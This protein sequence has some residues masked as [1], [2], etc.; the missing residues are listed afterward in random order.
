MYTQ[1][2]GNY[3]LSKGYITN[4]Q[5]FEALQEKSQKHTKLG[6]LAIHSGLM[7]AAEV[8]AV[9]VEQTHQDKK[10]GELTIEMGYLTD[11]QVKNL[12]NIQSPDFLLLG[13]ILLDN[14]IIDNTTLEKIINDYRGENEISDLDMVFEDKESVEHLIGHFFASA[15]VDP[16]DLDKMYLE[17]LFNSF[18]RFVGD[19]F[20]PLSAEPCEEFCADCCVKQNISG[21]YAIS[22]YIGMNQATAINFASRYVKEAFSVYDEYVQASLEDFLNLNNGLFTVNCSNEK[23]LELSLSAPEHFDGEQ[24]TLTNAYKIKVLYPFGT[25]HFIIA[26]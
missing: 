6:T 2:F 7:T 4:D 24:L 23:A 25:V 10:F 12:L 1:F 16:S 22:T 19:D 21:E 20:T 5:L 13:Q 3:L 15:G 11:E 14:G 9:I 8:D 26:F 18:I 17:L